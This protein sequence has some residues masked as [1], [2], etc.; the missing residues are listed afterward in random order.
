VRLGAAWLLA[1]ALTAC[2]SSGG[3][4][5]G[6]AIAVGA[7]L[8]FT[9]ALA[10]SGA[11]LE[12]ALLMAAEPVNQAGG[13]EGRPI[14][15]ISRD[16]HS[17][18]TRGLAAAQELV[19]QGVVAVIGPEDDTLA[20]AVAP[21]LEANH[22]LFLSPGLTSLE[23]AQSGEL[24][25]WFRTCT[26]TTTLAEALAKR[27]F[28]DGM[29]SMVLLHG[30]DNY[31]LRFSDIVAQR[32]GELGGH[33]ALSIEVADGQ[34]SYSDEIDEAVAVTA[35]A[36][37][38]V[39][40]PST[41]IAIVDEYSAPEVGAPHWYLAPPL[42]TDVLLRNIVPGNLDSAIGVAARVGSDGQRFAAAFA[43]RWNGD[44][45]S[46]FGFFYYDSLA[47]LALALASAQPGDGT[48][49]TPEATRDALRR[50]ATPTGFQ[51]TWDTLAD[52]IAA[53][54]TRMVYYYGLT[55]VMTLDALGDRD[56]GVSGYWQIVDNQR[57]EL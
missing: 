16:T 12:R 19:D 40:Q 1:M 7:L 18:T 21:M 28:A 29:K 34:A 45:P 55:G 25:Y 36:V 27:V 14:R 22:V 50:V 31:D 57:V 15:I 20:Q 23:S 17:D 26:S 46:T 24:S 47:L 41:G 6:N 39:V 13:I 38:L 32:F 11:N 5:S 35:D 30:G 37:V 33:V 54:A 49:A 52:G 48:P 2:S 4:G 53:A 8:P 44:S 43:S 51:T 9:G 10:A 3:T 42:D 56:E